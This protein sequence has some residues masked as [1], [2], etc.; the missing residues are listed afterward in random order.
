MKL[1]FGYS[2]L[3]VRHNPL[4][5]ETLESRV[6]GWACQGRSAAGWRSFRLM[7]LDA[8]PM[9]RRRV[10]VY[11][12]RDKENRVYSKSA[13]SLVFKALSLIFLGLSLTAIADGAAAADVFGTMS[14]AGTGTRPHSV[15]AGDV[16]GDGNMDI[17]VANCRGNN[18]SVLLG[19]GNGSVRPKRDFSVGQ[20]PKT[21]ELGDVNGDGALD[22]ITANQNSQNLSVRL[23]NGDGTFGTTA[24]YATAVL[25]PH[26]GAVGDVNRD[27]KLD[28]VIV[29][30][31]SYV[32][33][34][35]GLGNGT[36]A[37]TERTYATGN[38][39]RSV[40]IADLDNDGYKDIITGNKGS[41]S[42]S[43]L[44][45][46]RAGGFRP[47]VQYA[48]GGPVHSVRAGDLNHDGL[49]DLVTANHAKDT[50]SVLLAKSPGTYAKAVIYPAGVLPVSIFLSDVDMD[51]NLDVL[52]GNGNDN[53]PELVN[54]GAGNAVSVFHGIGNGTLRP[55]DDYP[56][57]QSPWSVIA[58]DLNCDDAPDLLAANYW[59]ANISIGLNTLGSAVTCPSAP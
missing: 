38:T 26:E 49:L 53:Y 25:K 44:L 34:R 58:A 1:C 11:L 4:E 37:A 31:S 39:L 15:R 2:L 8:M 13:K 43:V 29:G 23:G 24:S 59:N 27:G 28:L 40:T 50:I 17:V 9:H 30:N 56:V 55:K 21:A 14:T 20:C 48:A 54:L 36:F 3:A 46:N 10:G 47:Q 51:G 5:W 12:A 6:Q 22:L 52:V 16:N 35:R 33:V 45:N 57:G 7:T 18:V 19:N 41:S 32:G 42:V